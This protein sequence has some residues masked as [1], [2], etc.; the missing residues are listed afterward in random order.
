MSAKAIT[1]RRFLRGEAARRRVGGN[2]API[3]TADAAARKE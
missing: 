3:L 2:V 1:R